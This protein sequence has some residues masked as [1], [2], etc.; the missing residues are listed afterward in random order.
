M[1]LFKL[2]EV[3]EIKERRQNLLI[4][5]MNIIIETVPKLIYEYNSLKPSKISSIFGKKQIDFDNTNLRILK[6]NVMNNINTII[7][8]NERLFLLK[9]ELNNTGGGK[10]Q[11]KDLGDKIIQEAQEIKSNILKRIK[12]KEELKQSNSSQKIN[13]YTGIGIILI[14]FRKKLLS[15]IDYFENKLKK[16]NMIQHDY[17]EEA[18]QKIAQQE[19]MTAAL[20]RPLRNT[21]APTEEE[22]SEEF[23]KLK[24]TNG[25]KK[26][27]KK[28]VKKPIK[29]PVKKTV[30][31]P[32]KKTVKKPVKKTVKMY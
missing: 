3:K 16:Y 22:I 32:V 17:E 29:K 6:Y 13:V 30:K 18:K 20:S 1:R 21:Y 10:S 15:F 7:K 8:D 26:P 25:G 24:V 23:K 11:I 12:L 9:K 4:P 31:K 2:K 27:I 5:T 19:K 28:P 14:E